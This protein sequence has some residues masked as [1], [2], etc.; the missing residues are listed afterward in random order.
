MCL[1]LFVDSS[2]LKLFASLLVF[3][4]I[5]F[6]KNRPVLFPGWKSK[7]ATKPGFSFFKVYFV[8]DFYIFC[9]R[10]MFVFDMLDLIS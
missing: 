6:L 8:I 10:C 4:L 9:S 5:Y 7:E 3:L 1:D 2:A